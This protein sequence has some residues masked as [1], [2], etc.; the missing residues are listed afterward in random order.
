MVQ[1]PERERR[2]LVRRYG[3]DGRERATLR[4]LAEE[5]ALSRERIRQLQRTAELTLRIRTQL[6]VAAN[7]QAG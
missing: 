1:L 7:R 6:S 4:E 3:L 5:L 2:V